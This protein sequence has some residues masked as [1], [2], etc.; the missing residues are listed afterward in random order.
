MSYVWD[1]QPE[2]LEWY[3]AY[4][5]ADQAAREFGEAYRTFIA[6]GRRVHS[7]AD[8]AMWSTAGYANTA[9]RGVR[10]MPVWQAM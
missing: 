4:L 1:F 6:E 3:A 9:E 10:D 5:E 2:T 8:Y 7:P